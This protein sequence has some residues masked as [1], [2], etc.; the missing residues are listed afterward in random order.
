MNSLEI[1]LNYSI[2]NLEETINLLINK[3]KEF[4]EKGQHI[5]YKKSDLSKIYFSKIQAT[6][7]LLKLENIIIPLECKKL[8]EEYLN[9]KNK[10]SNNVNKLTSLILERENDIKKY[11]TDFEI[12]KRDYEQIKRETSSLTRTIYAFIEYYY[13][14]YDSTSNYFI[15][16]T[17]KF[18]HNIEKEIYAKNTLKESEYQ[19]LLSY[20]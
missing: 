17:K 5:F 9:E 10:I 3:G 12:V 13:S 11:E 8:Y 15:D 18:I 16:T 4:N 20:I 7:L 14:N 2:K 19:K 1:N 6:R